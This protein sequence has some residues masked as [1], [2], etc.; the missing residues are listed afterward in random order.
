MNIWPTKQFNGLR[1]G[2]LA[3]SFLRHSSFA[4]PSRSL[5]K[6]GA[7]NRDRVRLDFRVLTYD[8]F[9]GGLF[10]TNCYVVHAPEGAILFDAPEGVCDWLDQRKKIDLK[11]LLL[12]H[13]HIDHVQDVAKIK[14]RFNCPIGCH[15]E[16]A[17]M[18]S[19]REFFRSFGFELE[20]EPAQP[21]FLIEETP[22]RDF[23]GSQF[24]VMDV[25]GPR[26]GS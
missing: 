17:P 14:R 21:D 1:L 9:C 12:T 8:T 20:I 7:R 23:L 25:P 10:E 2:F 16:T 5:A 19:D 15:A 11:L 24:Q 4:L 18:I 3:L 6:A 22:S 13:G 26:P